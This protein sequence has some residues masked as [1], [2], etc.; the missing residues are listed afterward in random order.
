MSGLCGGTG[1]GTGKIEERIKSLKAGDIVALN[2]S[3]YGLQGDRLVFIDNVDDDKIHGYY[4]G[5][6]EDKNSYENVNYC[7]LCHFSPKYL[8]N[9][10][11]I[12]RAGSLAAK[13]V[14]RVVSEYRKNSLRLKM[15]EDKVTDEANKLLRLIE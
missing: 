7:I 2:N 10:E 12:A 15:I 8:T 9:L 14:T 11:V 5:I 13:E 4:Y 1:V 3:L 6:P